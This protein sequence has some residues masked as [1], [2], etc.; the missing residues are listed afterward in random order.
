M[1]VRE[2]MYTCVYIGM[3]TGEGTD[4]LLQATPM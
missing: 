3:S 2:Y 1:H 4:I